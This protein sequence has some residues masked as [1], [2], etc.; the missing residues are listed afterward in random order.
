MICAIVA[1]WVITVAG[2]IALCSANG[3]SGWDDD[4]RG[5]P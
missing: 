5:E 2:T 1:L 4:R 3:P